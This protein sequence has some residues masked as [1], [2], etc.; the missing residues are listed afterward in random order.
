M[1]TN[2]SFQPRMIVIH[3]LMVALFIA[4]YALIEAKSFYER[5]SDIRG[6]VQY[7]H[8]M[9]GLAIFSLVWIRLYFRLTSPYPGIIPT[10]VNWQ[11]KLAKLFHVL[12]YTLM[13]AMPIIGWLMMNAKGRPVELGFFELP[14]LI[15]KN[16]EMA[17]L[18]EEIHETAGKV[19]YGIIGFHAFA[20]LFHHYW[21][22]D[23]TLLRMLKIKKD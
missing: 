2:T 14:Q 20:A 18:L 12:L 5:G 4:V 21:L 23:N 22:K 7:W 9:A 8:M 17:E 6:M 3:W 16:K 13:I 19:G 10:P 11:D 1:T 15:S